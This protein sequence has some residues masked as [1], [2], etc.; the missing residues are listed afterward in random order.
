MGSVTHPPERPFSRTHAFGQRALL[1]RRPRAAGGIL[2][3]LVAVA[4]ATAAISALKQI[5]P[6]VS[7]SVVYL[8]AV[9][10]VS[11]YWGIALGLLCSLL[12]AAAFNYFHFPPTGGFTI[13]RADNWVALVA[14]V[15]VALAVSAV[16]EL[17]R[18][19]ALE[20]ERRR[21]QAD[22][23]AAMARELLLGE[24]TPWARPRRLLA[25]RQRDREARLLTGQRRH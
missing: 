1:V 24:D 3:S 7:L 19:R 6:V 18:S 21:R 23:A 22:L 5:A 12:S 8:P 9:L 15:V 20:A 25:D 16:A 17:A 4:V 13:A 11:T 2:V 14:F 10:L